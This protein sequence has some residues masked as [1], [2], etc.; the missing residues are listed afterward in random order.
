MSSPTNQEVQEIE[1]SH[2]VMSHKHKAREKIWKTSLHPNVMHSREFHEY[3]LF[4]GWILELLVPFV[5]IRYNILYPFGL[6][7]LS[8]L[9]MDSVCAKTWN[10]PRVSPGSVHGL[11][12]RVIPLCQNVAHNNVDS[13][14][15]QNVSPKVFNN[16]ADIEPHFYFC[17]FRTCEL[18]QVLPPP[19]HSRRASSYTSPYLAPVLHPSHWLWPK[20]V[21]S[22]KVIRADQAPRFAPWNTSL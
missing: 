8:V 20:L 4:L 21:T 16:K 17:F 9:E 6:G 14:S 5:I 1:K 13:V 11:P 10:G 7:M 3:Y 2:E 15:V 18:S 22:G 19:W 12:C